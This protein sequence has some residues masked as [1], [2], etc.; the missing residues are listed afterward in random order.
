M[1]HEYEDILPS[2]WTPVGGKGVLYRVEDLSFTYAKDSYMTWEGD[3]VFRHPKYRSMGQDRLYP[4]WGVYW[5]LQDIRNTVWFHVYRYEA[6]VAAYEA[7]DKGRRQDYY[8]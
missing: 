6:I 3:L 5:K 7:I 1:F 8:V 4:V 2:N